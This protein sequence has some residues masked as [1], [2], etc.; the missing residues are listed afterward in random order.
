MGGREEWQWPGW[1]WQ[2]LRW[3]RVA[4]AAAMEAAPLRLLNPKPGFRV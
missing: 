4:A 3:V 2:W 1:Q